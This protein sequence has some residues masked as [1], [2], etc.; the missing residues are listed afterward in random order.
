MEEKLFVQRQKKRLDITRPHKRRFCCQ[1]SWSRSGV[2]MSNLA[3]MAG[4][5][6]SGVWVRVRG[7]LREEDD[8]K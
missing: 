8:K 2:D 3:H 5:F 1:R 7:D 4:H 6:M